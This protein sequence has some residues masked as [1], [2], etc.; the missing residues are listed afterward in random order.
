MDLH[1][2]LSRQ[3]IVFFILAYVI[4]WASWLPA[5]TMPAVPGFVALIGLYAPAIAGLIVAGLADGQAGIREILSR[6][7]KW[8]FGVPWYLLALGLIPAIFV[9]AVFLTAA[10]SRT[11]VRHFAATNP[12]YFVVASF[13]FLMV[14]T[15]GEEIGWRGFALPR[16][17]AA[18]GSRL[19]ASLT[20]GVLWGVWHLPLYLLPGQSSFPF[21]LFLLL[22]TGLSI[23]YAVLLKNTQGS[24]LSVVLLHT[25]TD[26]M[27]RVMQIA[28][29]TVV[30]WSIIVALIWVFALHLELRQRAGEKSPSVKS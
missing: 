26:I 10:M 21:I 9:S 3:L 14:I 4:G 2:S 30:T 18:L 16:M 19:R 13:I 24:L 6:F 8:R 23:L 17:E 22:T 1:H 11:D 29:F 25:S 7:R 20:L 27:P 15:S 28:N 12:W 5:F